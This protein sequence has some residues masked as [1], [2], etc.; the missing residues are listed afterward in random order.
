MTPDVLDD[1]GV[2]LMKAAVAHHCGARFTGAGGGG[3][4][5]AL[6]DIKHIDSLRPMWEE[7]LLSEKEGRVLDV[8]I[9]SQGLVV[10]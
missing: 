2:Q 8:K 10:H 1:I 9:D 7:I 3:C 5:W 4:I 6:G